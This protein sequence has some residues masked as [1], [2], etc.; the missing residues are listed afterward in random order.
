MEKAKQ[1]QTH[2]R[3][4]SKKNHNKQPDEEEEETADTDNIEDKHDDKEH[5]L[6]EDSD[7][8]EHQVVEHRRIIFQ[9]YLHQKQQ[10]EKA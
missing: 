4:K 8:K 2:K 5:Q 7:D 6:V 9:N 1:I 10:R 3:E